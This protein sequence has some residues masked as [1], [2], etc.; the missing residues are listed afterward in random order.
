MCSSSKYLFNSICEAGGQ[1]LIDAYNTASKESSTR[2]LTAVRTHGELPAREIYFLPWTSNSDVQILQRTIK[3]F[4]SDAIEKAV[5]DHH[6]T[7]AFP[8]IECSTDLL[9][10]ILIAEV[11]Q[12]LF[13]HSISVLFI[14]EPNRTDIYDRF[15]H[16]IFSLQS[17]GEIEAISTPVGKGRMAAE[18]GDIT[19]QQ[20]IFQKRSS[21]LKM[22]SIH[23]LMFLSVFRHRKC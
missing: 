5:H 7:I 8:A 9:T 15:R 19:M 16:E 21:C 22:L 13:M 1:S 12:Q 2:S 3:K 14:V 23:R 18:L 4:L 20:V 11:D 17:S 6:Q 10:Q